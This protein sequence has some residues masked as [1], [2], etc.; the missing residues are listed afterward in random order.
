MPENTGSKTKIKAAAVG[1]ELALG[2]VL[3]GGIDCGAKEDGIEYQQNDCAAESFR[4]GYRLGCYAESQA[5]DAGDG[6]L[7][8]RQH[9]GVMLSG[10]AA[11]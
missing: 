5:H 4:C 10:K 11:D 2:D 3:Y 7:D 1:E 9:D 8:D 6:N